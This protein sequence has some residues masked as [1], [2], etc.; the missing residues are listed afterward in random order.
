MLEREGI[1]VHIQLIYSG[2]KQTQHCKASPLRFF[3]KTKRNTAPTS[4]S[5]AL[6]TLAFGTR[7]QTGSNV[8][9]AAPAT[10]PA[11]RQHQPPNP[12]DLVSFLIAVPRLQ[13]FL[14]NPHQHG[15]D[16]AIPPEPYLN[17]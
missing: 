3:K 5:H 16:Q 17:S 4:L 9:L 10:S 1:C 6:R 11:N 15:L 2:V 8:L 12:S 14:V 7:H 13:V